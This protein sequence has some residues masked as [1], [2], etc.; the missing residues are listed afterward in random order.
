VLADTG[1]STEL[2]F[3]EAL[4]PDYVSLVFSAYLFILVVARKCS[5]RLSSRLQRHSAVLYGIIWL[6]VFGTVYQL[7]RAQSRG[8]KYDALIIRLVLLTGLSL[9]HFAAPRAPA[10][11]YFGQRQQTAP[12][13]P[14]ETA[15]L[16][17]RLT[18]TWINKLA[19]KAYRASLEISELY[20]VNRHCRATVV[21]STFGSTKGDTGNLLWKM[22]SFCRKDLLRQLEVLFSIVIGRLTLV[23]NA[24]AG[25]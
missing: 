15:S 24:V 12:P 1:L 14:D 13:G 8:F 16:F 25:L 7:S 4:W 22:F 2:L 20:P 17:S 11:V 5:N 6:S 10:L 21:I 3:H 9:I 19:W 18:F 23:F